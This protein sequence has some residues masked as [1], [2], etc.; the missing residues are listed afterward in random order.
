MPELILPAS[1]QVM[2]DETLR[3]KFACYFDY[4]RAPTEPMK[5]ETTELEDSSVLKVQKW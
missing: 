3:T 4:S 5:E 2:D 1:E